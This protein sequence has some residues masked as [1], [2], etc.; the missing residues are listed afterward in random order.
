M[1][2]CHLHSASGSMYV[3]WRNRKSVEFVGKGIICRHLY[4]GYS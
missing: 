1:K 3:C 4:K 2:R